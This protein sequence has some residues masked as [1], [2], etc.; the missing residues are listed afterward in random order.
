LKKLLFVLL[1]VSASVSAQEYGIVKNVMTNYRLINTPIE[2]CRDVSR[3]PSTGLNAGTVIGGVA[4]GI[5]GNQVGKGGGNAVATAIGAG[6]GAIVG[7]DLGNRGE[8]ENK[9]V[10]TT[11]YRQRHEIENYTV[12][13]NYKGTIISSVLNYR[14]IIGSQVP[15][16]IIIGE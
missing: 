15:V 14:P 10:C 4:G 1:F 9:H 2:D 13:V 8:Y 5:I 16:T 3:R 7:Q 11:T 6:V 12:D